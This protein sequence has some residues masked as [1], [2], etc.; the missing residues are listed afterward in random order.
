MLT[1]DGDRSFGTI[2]I[3]ERPDHVVRAR[4]I[5]GDTWEVEAHRL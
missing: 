2:D 1:I 4:R 3:L 5:D